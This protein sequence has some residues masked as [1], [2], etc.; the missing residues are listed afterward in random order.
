MPIQTTYPFLHTQAIAG[1]TAQMTSL[2]RVTA[3]SSA[4]IGFGLGVVFDN[5]V[6]AVA[7]GNDR[8]RVVLPAA[9]ITDLR[10]FYGVTALDHKQNTSGSDPRLDTLTTT[11][12]SRYEIG[13]DILIVREGRIWVQCET[14][15]DFEDPVHIRHTVSGQTAIGW[16]RNA[17]DST[18]TTELSGATGTLPLRWACRTSAAGLAILEIG[19]P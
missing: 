9:A 8:P 1:M 18:N 17:A 13:D 11:A 4:A 2:D 3:F 16:F 14:A 15:V 7:E 6:D 10:N 12:L 5:A 19:L